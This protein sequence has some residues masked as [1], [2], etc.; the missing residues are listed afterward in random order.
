MFNVLVLK[1]I[2][3]FF[4][5]SFVFVS[6]LSSE[7]NLSWR[8]NDQFIFETPIVYENY[9][10]N[11]LVLLSETGPLFSGQL[12]ALYHI[13]PGSLKVLFPTR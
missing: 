10:G 12:C 6:E 8:K 9:Q 7:T 13:I 1:V 4:S 2:A 11:G 3:W 5:A